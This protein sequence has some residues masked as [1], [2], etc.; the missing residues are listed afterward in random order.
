MISLFLLERSAV[1]RK[2]LGFIAMVVFT[3]LFVACTPAQIPE[4]VPEPE[5]I[6]TLIDGLSSG[7]VTVVD[8]TQPLNAETPII[9]LPPP[10]ANTPGF[11]SHL[12]SNF[13]DDGPAWYW[14]WVEVG[15]HVG[16][17]FDAPCHW[18]SGRDLPC[19]DD[20]EASEF[21]GPAVVIDVTA[22]VEANPDF[23]ATR[24]TIENWEAEHGQIPSNA[25]VILY[26]GCA[27]RGQD[28]AAYFNADSSGVPHYPGFGLESATF[29][30]TERDILGVGT[31]AVGTDAAVGA[32]SDP[33]FPNHFTMHGAGKYG[34]TQLT[35]VNLLPTT[36]AVVIA[37]PLKIERG[38]GSPVRV[39]AL[40]PTS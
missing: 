15:E 19:V 23:V 14:N 22:E 31:E 29:L 30:A 18:I 28:A 35:N 3:G 10:L 32:T 36:G 27:S 21:I 37:T 33:P 11:T 12:I 34:L 2:V 7:K 1:M 8:L 6:A 39:I 38:S 5:P 9:Q 13:D 16:T 25:W 26:T 40:V 17:H 24:E 20:L 4:A